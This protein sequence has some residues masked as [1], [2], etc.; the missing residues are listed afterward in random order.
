MVLHYSALSALRY[1]VD[2]PLIIKPHIKH[3]SLSRVNVV[4]LITAAQTQVIMPGT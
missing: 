4:H 1:F 3:H 2:F